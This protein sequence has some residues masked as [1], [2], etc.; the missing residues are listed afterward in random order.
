MFKLK[1]IVMAVLMLGAGAA[2]AYVKHLQS[3]NIVLT[4][5]NAVQS[6]ALDQLELE[7]ELRSKDLIIKQG[8][9]ARKQRQLS[10]LSAINAKLKGVLNEMSRE[11]PKVIECLGV[12]PSDGFIDQLLEYSQGQ[13][14]SQD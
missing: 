14:R 1:I 7:L 13:N 10:N 12:K 3:E 9:V 8:Q 2:F 4:A 11:K 6:I 5:N